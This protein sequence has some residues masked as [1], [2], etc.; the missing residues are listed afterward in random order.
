MI[1]NHCEIEP[2]SILRIWPHNNFLGEK[3]ARY[4]NNSVYNILKFDPNPSKILDTMTQQW[5]NRAGN[6]LL[7]GDLASL[8]AFLATM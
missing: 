3:T 6:D 1:L 5:K 8:T 4:F 7:G 2:F